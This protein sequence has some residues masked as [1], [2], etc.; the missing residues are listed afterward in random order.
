LQLYNFE[1]IESSVIFA[2]LYSFLSFGANTK[3]DAPDSY[4]R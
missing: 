2:T 4:F 3:L 1:L